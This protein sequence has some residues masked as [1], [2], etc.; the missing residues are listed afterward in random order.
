MELI[1]K[2]KIICIIPARGGS[3][4]IPHKNLKE[5]D[6]ISLVGRAIKTAYNSKLIN[7]VY[8]SS[9]DNKILAE[10]EKYSAIPLKRSMEASSDESSTEDALFDALD[11]LEQKN[12][13][14]E[15]F[16][17]IQCT[18]PF[19]NSEDIDKAIKLLRSNNKIDTVFS[20]VESHVFLWGVENNIGFGTNHEAYKQ[21][22]RRQDLKKTYREDGCFYV[23]RLD[24]FKKTMNRFGTSALPYLN[25]LEMPFEIDNLRE[26]EMARALVPFFKN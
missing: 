17:Y 24:R 16:V 15:I 20:A 5:I 19:I 12:N 6:G 22:E 23:L 10:A 11:K 18:S 9:D 14:P 2:D 21:R 8:V 4:G 1:E 25:S 3:K 7:Q 26:L 13:V